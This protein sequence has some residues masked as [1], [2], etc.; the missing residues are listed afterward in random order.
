ML[1]YVIENLYRQH[2]L[3]FDNITNQMKQEMKYDSI[4]SYFENLQ[5]KNKTFFG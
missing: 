3:E 1:I 2:K 4:D 5:K